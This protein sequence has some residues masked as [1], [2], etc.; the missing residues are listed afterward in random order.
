M[1]DNCVL[2]LNQDQR[3]TDHDGKGNACDADLDNDGIV[4]FCDLALMKSVFFKLNSYSATAANAD[5]NGD[6]VVNFADLAKLKSY[7]FLR[8]G[9]LPTQSGLSCTGHIPCP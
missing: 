8:P 1:V 3:D 9:G 4:N 6:G 2:V 7:F 5:L